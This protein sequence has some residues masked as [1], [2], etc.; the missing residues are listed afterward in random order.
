MREV[1]GYTVYFIDFIYEQECKTN[2]T[3]N[4]TVHTKMLLHT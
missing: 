2:I 4:K 3:K 1:F